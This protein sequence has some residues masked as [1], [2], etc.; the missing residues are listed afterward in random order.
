MMP[1]NTMFASTIMTPAPGGGEARVAAALGK[2]WSKIEDLINDI[3]D[4]AVISEFPGIT[5]QLIREH[6]E[7]LRA[8]ALSI[9]KKDPNTIER[10]LRRLQVNAKLLHLESA[11]QCTPGETLIDGASGRG[12]A[13]EVTI[14]GPELDGKSELTPGADDRASRRQS[15]EQSPF[16]GASTQDHRDQPR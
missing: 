12:G 9:R 1:E 15:A 5:L 11:R 16:S 10:S 13:G 2:D 7:E 4:P 3:Q 8:A 14:E 6:F